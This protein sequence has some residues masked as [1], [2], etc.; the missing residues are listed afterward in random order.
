M[1]RMQIHSEQI[2]GSGRRTRVSR[3]AGFSLVEMIV[4][5]ALFS[6]VMLIAVGALLALVDANRKARALESVMNNLNIALDGLVRGIRMGSVYHCGTGDPTAAQDCAASGGATIA[7]ESYGGD[8]TDSTD[9]WIYTYDEAT[10]RLYRS[11]DGGL[12]R[13]AVT[14]PDITI[15]E[16]RFY[17]TGTSRSDEVQPKVVV[18]VKG[19]AGAARVKTRSTFYIQATAVQRLLDL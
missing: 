16:M 12:N 5:V 7:F 6:V 13:T 8:P 11:T 1:T 3:Q 19:T 15:D 17:V 18:T 2:P 10:K 9:Q 14:A 4:A